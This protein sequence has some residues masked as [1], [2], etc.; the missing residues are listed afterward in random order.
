MNHIASITI[1]DIDG[2]G[3]KEL[4]L[5]DY[6]PA[7]FDIIVNFG[8]WRG[9][10]VVFTWDGLHFLLS[11]VE[12]DPPEYRFQ[13]LQDADRF[14]LMGDYD[15]ALGYYQNVIFSK[16]LEWWSE[17]R[18]DYERQTYYASLLEP[19]TPIP[20]DPD[21]NEYPTLAAYARY[22]ILL[23]HLT[24]GWESDA[25]VIYDSLQQKFPQGVTGHQYASLATTLWSSYQRSGDLAAACSE[26][27]EYVDGHQDEILYPLNPYHY[28]Q[29]HRYTPE[30]ICPIGIW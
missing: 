29:S 9:K 30:D 12:M 25:K 23:L 13:A 3:T 5:K 4:V 22:R 20:P 18:K 7:G 14:F 6:G 8:P 19:P 1:T 11:F 27:I 26:V 2:N 15:R 24:L 10:R 21:P 17:E 16:G 28:G